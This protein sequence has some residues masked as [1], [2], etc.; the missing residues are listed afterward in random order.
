MEQH[1]K[2]I[3]WTKHAVQQAKLRRATQD[4]VEL[5]VK[6]MPWKNAERGL[7][8]CL[9]TF[10]FDGNIAGRYYKSVDVVPIFDAQGEEIAIITVY[11]FFNQKDAE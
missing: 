11:T 5:A 6:T 7:F 2:P 4:K 3:R 10:R 8:T 9:R 1:A